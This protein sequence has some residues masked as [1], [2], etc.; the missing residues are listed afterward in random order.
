MLLDMTDFPYNEHTTFFLLEVNFLCI[1]YY[2]IDSVKLIER[3]TI[4]VARSSPY[5]TT[6]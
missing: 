2:L 4:F 3:E 5:E 1:T 6:L